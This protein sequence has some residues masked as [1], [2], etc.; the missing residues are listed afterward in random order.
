[1]IEI[2]AIPAI[3]AKARECPTRVTNEG[4]KIHPSKKPAKCPEAM[5]PI[6]IAVKPSAWPEMVSKGRSEPTPICTR[7]MERSNADSAISSFMRRLP[8]LSKTVP[9]KGSQWRLGWNGLA[10]V[11]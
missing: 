5:M 9:E 4:L 10:S 2:T 7:P 11:D 3:T 8:A 6:S 1:M